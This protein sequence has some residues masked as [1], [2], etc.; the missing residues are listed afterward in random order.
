MVR[1]RAARGWLA[2]VSAAE[3]MAAMEFN[4]ED[5]EMIAVLRGVVDR[6]G[7]AALANRRM[8]VGLLRDHLPERARAIRLL[9][10]AYDGGASAAF[11]QHPTLE[12][13]ALESQARSLT[14]ETGLRDD[15]ARWAVGI[16][17]AALTPL[18]PEPPPA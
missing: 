13:E 4:A 15:L 6:R 8:L 7:I 3:R 1:A 12:P 11:A 9:M 14:G 17:A 10:T 16:W 2:P 18:T 5:R